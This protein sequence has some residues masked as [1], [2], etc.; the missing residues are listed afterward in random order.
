MGGKKPK[1]VITDGDKAVSEA[2]S[3]SFPYATHCLSSWH[4]N[5]N[6]THNVKNNKF[7]SGWEKFVDANYRVGEFTKKRDA[8]VEE[9][10]QQS[11]T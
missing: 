10:E 11:N 7:H 1:E 8:F 6:V 3:I 9:C 4:V 2:I 5:K